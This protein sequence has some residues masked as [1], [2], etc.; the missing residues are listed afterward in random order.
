MSFVKNILLGG[1]KTKADFEM[2]LNKYLA[3]HNCNADIGKGY[4]M[5]EAGACGTFSTRDANELGSVGI[6]LSKTTISVF[7]PGT[8]DELQY[9]E[10]GEIYIQTPTMMQEYYNKKEETDDVK[11]KHADGYWI[12]SGDL[13]YIDDNGIV[14][15]K[16]RIKRMIIR[17]KI[18]YLLF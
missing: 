5:T 4:S 8:Q 13:G 15:V 11:V 14:F 6:P 16:D 1:D 12:H 9:N 2:R 17:K 7:E 10:V 18:L 3:E